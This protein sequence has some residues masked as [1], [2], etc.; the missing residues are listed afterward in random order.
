LLPLLES[1]GVLE[2]VAV[3]VNA[4]PGA[5]PVGMF[6][7]KVKFA[8]APLL[9]V[10]MLQVIVPFV[11]PAGTEQLNAGPVFCVSETKV[12]PAGSGSVHCTV[13]AGAVPLLGI[14]TWNDTWRR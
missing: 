3:F 4:V 7:T 12:I 5:V 1:A 10:A 11:P 14:V 13:V 2:A 9:S 8:L 6:T